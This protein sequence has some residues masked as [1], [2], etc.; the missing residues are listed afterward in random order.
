M[1]NHILC[2]KKEIMKKFNPLKLGI[3]QEQCPECQTF[4]SVIGLDEYTCNKVFK[5]ENTNACK[6][7]LFSNQRQYRTPSKIIKC[8]QCHQTDKVRV[9]GNDGTAF[10][11]R[12]RELHSNNKNFS[13]TL[14]HKQYRMNL[15]QYLTEYIDDTF[16]EHL[17]AIH[18]KAK[19]KK[20]N[21][22]HKD[23]IQSCFTIGL[24]QT[25]IAKIYCVNQATIS[26]FIK[27][28]KILKHSNS[29]FVSCE[30]DNERIF[31]TT[32]L[33]DSRLEKFLIEEE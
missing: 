10:I 22:F 14:K 28:K 7:T 25:V 29:T 17:H 32:M 16:Y 27:E 12:D 2:I 15:K 8:P 24:N 20:E 19:K 11:C 9:N 31:Y 6:I 33:I 13:F 23:T 26:R 1:C 3:S 18:L 5:C 4:S 21:I 30:F